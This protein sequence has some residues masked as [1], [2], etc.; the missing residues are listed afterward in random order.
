MERYYYRVGGMLILMIME[1]LRARICINDAIM[2][3][4]LLDLPRIARCRDGCIIIFVRHAEP[5]RLN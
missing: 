1:Y 4:I 5:V 2:L 3:A